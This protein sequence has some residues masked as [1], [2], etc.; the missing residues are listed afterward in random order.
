MKKLISLAFHRRGLMI[1]AFCFVA[2]IGYYSWKQL[3]KV[4]FAMA[5]NMALN[6]NATFQGAAFYL[7]G[8]LCL[9]VPNMKT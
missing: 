8:D 3:A 2:A 6:G 4:L 9:T 7:N 5:P 1:V